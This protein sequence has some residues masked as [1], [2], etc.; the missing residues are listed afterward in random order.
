MIEKIL[1]VDDSP[2]SR[3]IMKSC[4]PE[5]KG[6]ELFE[7]GDGQSGIDKY[8][9]F[10]PDLTFMD[11]TMPVM[12]GMQALQ[13]IIKI[14]PRAV[15]VVCTADVQM[16]SIFKVMNLGA[17]MVVRKPINKQAIEDALRKAEDKLQNIK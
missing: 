7:A 11:L 2:V 6:Y 12:D 13:E 1:I 15:V 5:D 17:L 9:E 14:D 10:Q 4:I 3:K 16:K 8:Q